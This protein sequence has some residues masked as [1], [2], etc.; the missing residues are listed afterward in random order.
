MIYP[1]K[2]K[3]RRESWT[4]ILRLRSLCRRSRT[5]TKMTRV[6]WSTS[7]PCWGLRRCKQVCVF[8]LVHECVCTFNDIVLSLEY[9]DW[10]QSSQQ[11]I[12]LSQHLYS[13]SSRAHASW[14][15]WNSSDPTPRPAL[16]WFQ[17]SESGKT[18]DF[19]VK[20]KLYI[21]ASLSDRCSN[22]SFGLILDLKNDFTSKIATSCLCNFTSGWT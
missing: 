18:E 17:S 15:E 9:N 6:W 2:K 21:Y 22:S 11:Q 12:C 16:L 10:A 14:Y 3:P 7:K 13:S 20:Q 5:W 19:I 8:A 1:S 4:T